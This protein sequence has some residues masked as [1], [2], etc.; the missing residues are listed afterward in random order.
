MVA[1]SALAAVAVALFAA[2]PA[3][4]D[5]SLGAPEHSKTAILDPKTGKINITLS[6]TGNTDTSE[7]KSSANLIVVL[8]KSGSMEQVV[9]K[10]V[11]YVADDSWSRRSERY[12]LVGDQYVS[13]SREWQG[14]FFD[15]KYIYYYTDNNGNDVEYTGQR[16]RKETTDV[17]RLDVAKSA[18]DGLADQLISDEKSTV[19]ISLETFADSGETPS[20]YYGAGEADAFKKLV[21]GQRA[22]GGTNWTDALEKAN[23]KAKEDSSTPTY[24]VFLSDGQPTYGKNGTGNGTYTTEQFVTDAVNVA[25]DRPSNVLGFYA[26]YTGAD[27]ATSM[28]NFASRTKASPN[29]QAID[30]SN[31]PALQSAFSN[32]VQTINKGISYTNVKITDSNSGYVDYVLPKGATAPVFTYQKNGETWAKAPQAT[33]TNGQVSWNLGDIKLE[34][35]VTYSVSFEVTLKQEAYDKAALGELTDN[36]V[37]TNSTAQLAY[38]TVVSTNGQEETTG[39]KPIDIPSPTVTVPRSTLHVSKTWN[40]NGWNNV[41]LP[42]ELK[43][44]VMQDGNLYKIVTLNAN[45]WKADVVVAAGPT[46]HTYTVKEENAPAGWEATLLPKDGVKLTGLTSQTGDQA[47]TNTIKT[48]K[49]TITKS[50]TGNFGDTSKAFNFTLTDASD[51]AITNVTTVTGDK[52]TSEGVSLGTDGSF[53]LKNGEKLV[54]ELPYGASYKV[55]EKDPKGKNDTVDYTT[56]IDAGDSGATIDKDTPTVSSPEGGI[57]KDTTITYTNKRDV[58]P[59]VGVDLGSGAPYAA[60]FGGAGL[61]GVIW[62]VLKR[63]NSLGI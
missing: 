28:N 35:D 26:I 63:R 18:L 12:G 54:V 41:N 57:A 31:S 29:K 14:G 39:Q 23:K 58:T 61:A 4:A 5:V 22:V 13:L 17:T 11:S 3:F 60:V 30:G 15:G 49:L 6:V 51:K 20:Q 37:P 46:G 50:V 52:G 62:M 45:E 59:D 56:T 43:V 47:I 16:Y 1:V 10:K 19:K 44:Q 53:K 55:V 24:I 25:N 48:A 21:D 40:T 32:I 2:V 7:S 38:S 42:S 8:D 33:T 34:K 27:A 36:K 9:D